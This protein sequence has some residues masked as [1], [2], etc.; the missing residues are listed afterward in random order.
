MSAIP[1]IKFGT[2]DKKVLGFSSSDD[3][4]KSTLMSRICLTEGR[5]L[6]DRK[7]DGNNVNIIFGFPLWGVLDFADFRSH[8][9]FHASRILTGK[10]EAAPVTPIS[11]FYFELLL[12]I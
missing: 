8:V 10:H 2:L 12:P 6:T 4:T 3:A 1:P 5:G 11:I 7:K 9:C